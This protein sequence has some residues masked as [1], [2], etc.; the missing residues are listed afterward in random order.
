[1]ICPIIMKFVKQDFFTQNQNL[2]IQGEI[3]EEEQKWREEGK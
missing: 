3:K 1:M 2:V